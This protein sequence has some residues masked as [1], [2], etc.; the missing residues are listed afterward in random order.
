MNWH[1]VEDELPTKGGEYW[2]MVG[3]N[4]PDVAWYDKN[5]PHWA[6]V[7]NMWDL[8]CIGTVTHWAEIEVPK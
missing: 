6:P 2:V 8:D 3:G 1:K 4:K 5:E 7:T